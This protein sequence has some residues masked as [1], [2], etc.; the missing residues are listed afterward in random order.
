MTTTSDQRGGIAAGA[1]GGDSPSAPD[2]SA[3]LQ[4][5]VTELIA[6]VVEAAGLQLDRLE[7]HDQGT[8]VV[9]QVFVDKP[10]GVSVGDC[11]E[12]S[13]RLEVVLDAH[14]PFGGPWTL[15]VSSPGLT[16]PLHGV[17]EY[18]RF[19][20]RLAVLTLR[21]AIDGR[22]KVVGRLAGV[23]DGTLRVVEQESAAEMRIPLDRIAKARL[24]VEMPAP[25]PGRP[26][27]RSGRK[28]RAGRA[29]RGPRAGGEVGER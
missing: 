15:E 23:E 16:R 24:E 10:G 3:R 29:G 19:A 26:A 6:P 1:A 28:G 20:G 11:A 12:V 21:G 8:R 9:L 5:G 27:V 22:S 13:H 7:L 2:R 25:G 4:A 18:L 17:D 14:D